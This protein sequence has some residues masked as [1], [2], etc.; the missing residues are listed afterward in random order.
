MN[1]R[2]RLSRTFA[3]S[4]SAAVMLGVTGCA[5]T[6]GGTARDITVVC[7]SDSSDF[8]ENMKKGAADGGEEML[9]NITF[10]V[11]D[12]PSPEAQAHGSAQSC[13]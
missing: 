8:W 13:Q 5:K 7:L 2:K 3:V 11:P 12:D 9:C 10:A 1:L 4:A 6:G